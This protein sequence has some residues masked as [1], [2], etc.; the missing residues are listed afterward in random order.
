MVVLAKGEAVGGVVVVAVGERDEVG[1]VDEGDVLCGGELDAEAAGGALV[2]VDFEDLAA[3][4]GAAAVFGRV[5]GDTQCWILNVGSVVAA[6]CRDKF[7]N[8]RKVREIAGD[9]GLAH[10]LAGGG[11]GGEVLEAIGEAGEGLILIGDAEVAADDGVSINFQRLPETVAGEVAEW[12][13]GV[14]LVVVFADLEEAGG[15]TISQRLAPRDAVRRGEAFIDQ[16]E[17]GEQQQRFVRPF[18]P[19]ST[20]TDDTHVEGVEAFDGGIER[21]AIRKADD[22]LGGKEEVWGRPPAVGNSDHE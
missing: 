21:H 17:G 8:G 10:S 12:Q 4:G 22:L 3:E 7:L 16:I 14:V 5:V 6:L 19:L 2:I 20:D 11:D 15:E 18:V 1:G 13:L 9:E